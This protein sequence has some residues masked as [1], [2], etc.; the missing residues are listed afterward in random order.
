MDL[1][2]IH[3]DETEPTCVIVEPEPTTQPTSSIIVK[4]KG[5]DHTTQIP[6]VESEGY[7]HTAGVSGPRR[8]WRGYPKSHFGNWGKEQVD[9]SGMLTKC[10]K[11]GPSSIYWMDVLDDGRFCSS[12]IGEGSKTTK[13]VNENG[14]WSMLETLETL[15]V[16]MICPYMLV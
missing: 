7:E 11:T 9:H 12:N 6:S 15:K 2:K 8:G 16:S 1:S 14:F 3:S 5:S 4:S 10:S 13:K